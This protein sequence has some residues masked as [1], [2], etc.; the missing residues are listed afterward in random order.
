MYDHATSGKPRLAEPLAAVL[1]H[2][3]SPQARRF[4]T[5][6]ADFLIRVDFK[7]IAD[8]PQEFIRSAEAHCSSDGVRHTIW[9]DKESSDFEA[10]VMHQ[11]M[12]G[13]LMEEG[14]P[15]TTSPATPALDARLFYLASLLSCA[16]IDP[17]IDIRLMESGYGVYD[18]EILTRRTMEKVWLDARAGTPKPYGFLFCKWTLLTV[19]LKLDPT[20]K[21]ETVNLLH[22][23][24]HKKFLEPWELADRFSKF[25]LN[26]GFRQPYSALIA[27]LHLRSALKLEDKV[28]IL[29]AEGTRY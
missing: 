21:G 13:I 1:G 29:D 26:K 7:D 20:F 19:L 27:L 3:L 2:Q 16:V 28:S 25:M 15:R 14:F 11:A 4:A 6:Y 12:R 10:L 23:L 17:I 9:L 18:R 8:H 5:E 24:I 22:A